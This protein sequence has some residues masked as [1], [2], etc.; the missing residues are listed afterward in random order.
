LNFY[1]P[2]PSLD[3][4]K[5]FVIGEQQRSELVRYDTK[6]SQFIPYLNGISA[7][8][9]S[10]SRDGK[11]VSYISYPE[12]DLWRSR[13]DGTDKLQLTSAPLEVI[14]ARWSPDGRDI[15][16]SASEPG[17]R[18]RLF[19]VTPDGGTP[20]EVAIGDLSAALVS[21]SADGNSIFFND[22]AN[23]T[24]RSIRSVDLHTSNTSVVAGSEAMVSPHLS[25]DG[26][27]LAAANRLGDRLMLYSFATK[28]WSTLVEAPVGA[29]EWSADSKY[30]YFDNGFTAQ[31]G[32]FR[33]GLRDLRVQ[34]VA[35]LTDF[36][37]VVSPWNTWLGIT[38]DGAP[39][40]MRDT[41]SQEVY[42]L[43]F[44]AR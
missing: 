35:T 23:V 31:Q 11:W 42:A 4:K 24:D 29:L 5:L 2:Q 21:W 34:R 16:F 17:T 25:P 13:I 44:E 22:T 3:G 9:V 32:I 39:L 38:P 15:A 7:R 12:G 28:T 1:A 33:V 36:R 43:D 10:F 18:G 26:Q 41:G 40:L 8:G 6:S 30:L 27:Y 37:R 20:R 14:S 19:L